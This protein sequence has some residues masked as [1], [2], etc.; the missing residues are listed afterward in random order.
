MAFITV[1]IL[2]MHATMT[3][4]VGL[5]AALRRVAKALIAGLKRIALTTA[6]YSA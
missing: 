3:T 1:S 5:P 4:L 2:R 6:M